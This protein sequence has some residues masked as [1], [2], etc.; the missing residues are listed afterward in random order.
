MVPTL[1][2]DGAVA[3]VTGAARGIGRAIAQGLLA[4]G[5]R[6]AAVDVDR[7]G[8]AATLGDGD[9]LAIAADVTDPSA[10]EQA[11]AEA[12][13]GLGP[14]KILV[15]NA[16]VVARM[17]FGAEGYAE[18][19]DRVF[20]VNVA[21]VRNMTM[22][23]L[24]DLRATGGRVVNLASVV[25]FVSTPNVSAYVASK[26][27]VAQLTKALASELAADGIRVNA[28]APGVIATPMTEP[29][30]NDPDVIARF[31]AHTPMRRVGRPEELVGPVLFLVSD[32]AS[33]VT[34]AILPVDGG[35]LTN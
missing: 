20:A 26:G 25:S 28:I 27:A 19:W 4:A 14:V 32:H 15:N 22:A 34:G 8:A 7:E 9:G 12:R 23:A 17:P 35:Y 5:A 29:T 31:A 21:G 16:G 24:G 30:V 33:Y 3:V 2:L 1:S 11:V 10:C 13:A 18:A 6:V